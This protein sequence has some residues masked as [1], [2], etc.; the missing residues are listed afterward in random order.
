MRPKTAKEIEAMR[1]G[2]RML[3]VVLDKVEK[4]VAPGISTKELAALAAAELER[5]G[6][7]PAF[8]N[9]D[10]FPDVMTI[11]INEEIVHGV[12]SSRR[13]VKDGDVVGLDF[14]VM[15]QGLIV[16]GARTIYV[17]NNP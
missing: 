3:A 7:Q 6:G 1:E 11:S 16:D 5:L 10:G 12:P 15:I 2:G 14:G 8:L 13:Q 4:A 9:H 17:G